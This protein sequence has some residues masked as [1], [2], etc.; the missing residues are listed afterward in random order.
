M[1]RKGKWTWH[2]AQENTADRMDGLNRER[3][4]PGGAGEYGLGEGLDAF[5]H[6]V[7]VARGK[8]FCAIIKPGNAMPLR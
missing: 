7:F 3:D 4:G 1:V 2:E 6:Q 8:P 5:S